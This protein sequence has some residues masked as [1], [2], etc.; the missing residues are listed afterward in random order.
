[1][2]IREFYKREGNN[3]YI[4][5]P[6]I[7]ELSF[8]EKLWGNIEN[9]NT[10]G[11]V[12]SFPKEKWDMFY[13]KMVYPTDGKNFYCLV[14]D[15]NN[16]AIGEVSF[17]GYNSATKVARI[18]IKIHYKYRRKGYA[19]EALR[20]LL[21]YYF[22]DFGGETIIDS[23]SDEA[24]NNLLKNLGF[25][26]INKF[27]NKLTYKLEKSKFSLYKKNQKK[28]VNI[29]SYDEMDILDY[30]LIVK[31]FDNANEILGDEYF[32]I[33]T[34]SFKENINID[35]KINIKIDEKLDELDNKKG[36][37]IIPSTNKKSLEVEEE[38]FLEILKGIYKEADNIL[39][40]DKGKYI[41]KG[42]FKND[43]TLKKYE[44]EDKGKIITSFNY[45]DKIK[46]CINIIRKNL[47]EEI[48]E[49]LLKEIL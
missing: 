27:Q 35:N 5:S 2:I 28:V 38:K 14:Y 7:D 18:N 6:D 30:S 47:G 11:G 36:I 37:Y 9:M 1:M 39:V 34:I 44:Y 20:L 25:E 40:F 45:K 16:N 24:S 12:Y 48:S 41:I 13:K 29:I 46:A 10:V 31:I 26:V 17:H 23:V 33:K 49:H 32:L 42:L 43:E 15:Y 19:K 3:I 8:V 21:E 22:W 4:K